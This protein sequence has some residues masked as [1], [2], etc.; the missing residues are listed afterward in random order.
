M[1]SF[2][3]YSFFVVPHCCHIGKRIATPIASGQAARS[4]LDRDRLRVVVR[5]A[6][7]MC[8]GMVRTP[9]NK[10]CG[11]IGAGDRDQ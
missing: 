10:T 6:L 3:E 9:G 4:R 7:A 8:S 2:G 5:W 1:G 11:G